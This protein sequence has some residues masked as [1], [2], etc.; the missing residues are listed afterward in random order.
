MITGMSFLCF[1]I[2]CQGIGCGSVLYK[3]FALTKDFEKSDQPFKNEIKYLKNSSLDFSDDSTNF[4]VA[5]L[6]YHGAKI[7]DMSPME[8]INSAIEINPN[9]PEYYF[10]KAVM[11]YN[12]GITSKNEMKKACPHFNKA[13]ELGINQE[14]KG[15]SCFQTLF[16]LCK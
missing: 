6:N 15:L 14:I 7:N 13:L 10:L 2:Y 16:D 5:Y 3:K 12:S 8:L 11:V 9:V 1:D 4:R